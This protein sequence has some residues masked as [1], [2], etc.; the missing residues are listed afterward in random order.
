MRGRPIR[1]VIR[2]PSPCNGCT[3]RFTACSGRCPKDARG[4]KGYNAWTGEIKRVK[5]EKQEYLNRT[6]V[7]MKSYNG[8]YY[9]TTSEN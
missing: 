3:E 2:D 7:R 4:E 5:K 6:N 1:S 8:G 9:E